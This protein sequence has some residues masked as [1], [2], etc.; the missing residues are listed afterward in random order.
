MRAPRF[1]DRAYFARIATATGFRPEPLETVFRLGDLLHRMGNYWKAELL[2]RGGT[3]LN[4]LHLDF[5]RLSVDV[6]LDFVGTSD[7]AE[8]QRRRPDI[9]GEIEEIAL[10]LGYDVTSERATY[11]MSHQLLHYSDVSG[12]PRFLRIDT[13]FLDRVPV[14]ESESRRLKHP[15]EEDLPDVEIQTFALPELTA[16]KVIALVRR[17]A[18]RDLFDVA[19][20]AQLA[21]TDR[22]LI[23]EVLVVRAASYPPPGPDDYDLRGIDAVRNPRWKSEVVALGRR[24]L[25]VDIDEAKRLASALM[26]EVLSLE[27]RHRDFLGNL[28]RGAVDASQLNLPDPSRVHINPGLLWRLRVGAQAL[29]ER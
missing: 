18:A 27:D 24:P 15:F 29:E 20:L 17:S 26:D 9:V 7:A 13:N 19:M 4:L 21:E 3:A 8:A 23:R 14:L 16:S 1:P 10:R 25:P 6:D 28:E 12:R 11:A 22:E 5:P 2:L